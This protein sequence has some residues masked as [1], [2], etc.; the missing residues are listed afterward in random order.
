MLFHVRIIQKC[1]NNYIF[2]KKDFLKDSEAHYC[3]SESFFTKNV[4]NINNYDLR[5]KKWLFDL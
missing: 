3:A 4:K 2:S 1:K 5:V